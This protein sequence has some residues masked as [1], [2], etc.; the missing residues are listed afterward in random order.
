MSNSKKRQAHGWK[1]PRAQKQSG[2]SSPALVLF[3]GEWTNTQVIGMASPEVKAAAF[4][5]LGRPCVLCGRPSR[6]AGVMSC[7]PTPAYPSLSPA[8]V[9]FGVCPHCAPKELQEGR[10]GAEHT[11]PDQAEIIKAAILR[12]LDQ[13]C[14]PQ[15]IN[16]GTRE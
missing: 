3:P 6:F 15:Y 7:P 10:V 14:V 11:N 13:G 2:T 12:A 5:V 9:V 4:F 1:N 16:R 8:T